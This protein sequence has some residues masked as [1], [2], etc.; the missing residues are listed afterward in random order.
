MNNAATFSSHGKCPREA[1]TLETPHKPSKKALRK[2]PGAAK[3]CLNFDSGDSTTSGQLSGSHGV[4]A[5]H[6][7]WSKLELR[8]L[9]E[10]VF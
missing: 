5:Q 4:Q 9:L 6:E 2:G 10:F 7:T 8:G 1:S 3:R